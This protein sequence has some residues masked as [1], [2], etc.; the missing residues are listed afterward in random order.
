MIV[1]RYT[2]SGLRNNPFA[3]TDPGSAGN[4]CFV[5]RGLS[6]PP[7]RSSLT[8]VQVIG[9]KGAGKSTQVHEWRRT[10]PGPYHYVAARPYRDRW[11]RPPVE[12][13]VYADEIDR[14]PVPLRQRWFRQLAAAKSTVV[15]GTHVDL[16]LSARR[17]GL[18]VITHHIGPADLAI[19][20][21]VLI[22]KIKQASLESRVTFALAEFEIEDIHRRCGGS[23]RAAEVLAHE[24]VA[25]R[26]HHASQ[27][28]RFHR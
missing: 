1:D 6:T 10:A 5:D 13:L 26:V 20:R 25:M 4:S 17:A 19:I 22:A 27:P 23:L 7:P 11:A 9:D 24:L 8:L 12:P 2:S 3:A 14:M 16:G 21:Q 18:A 28:T 15:A